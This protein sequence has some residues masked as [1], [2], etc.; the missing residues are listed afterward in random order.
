MAFAVNRPVPLVVLAL[1]RV[2]RP[3]KLSRRSQV[4]CVIRN[5]AAAWQA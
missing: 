4:S 3:R 5:S 1:M 2:N